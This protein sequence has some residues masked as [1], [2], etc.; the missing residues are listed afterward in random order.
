MWCA[1]EKKR[2]KKGGVGGAWLQSPL[3][4]KKPTSTL[5][6]PTLTWSRRIDSGISQTVMES[7]IY[8]PPPPP[9]PFFVVLYLQ[10]D[11]AVE[12]SAD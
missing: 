1:S 12:A 6:S 5:L 10:L 3:P 4:H 2:K 7:I 11:H 8:S 9:T